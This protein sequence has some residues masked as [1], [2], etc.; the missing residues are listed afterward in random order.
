MIRF[1]EYWSLPVLSDF[2]RFD[3]GWFWTK[4]SVSRMWCTSQNYVQPCEQFFLGIMFNFHVSKL[5]IFV[6]FLG[7]DRYQDRSYYLGDFGWFCVKFSFYKVLKMVLKVVFGKFWR[8]KWAL[9]KLKNFQPCE[10]FFFF[11][12]CPFSIVFERLIFRVGFWV[13]IGTNINRR[14]SA[15]NRNMFTWDWVSSPSSSDLDYICSFLNI[16]YRF[17]NYHRFLLFLTDSVLWFFFFSSQFEANLGI[18][19]ICFDPWREVSLDNYKCVF[20]PKNYRFSRGI[21]E[22]RVHMPSFCYI[23]GQNKIG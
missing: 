16:T 21:S 20:K 4:V 1:L 19:K 22:W 3:V 6:E 12:S 17:E 2:V 9:L 5:L 8:R 13:T 18:V 7:Q 15:G 14:I 23:V 10:N 11:V